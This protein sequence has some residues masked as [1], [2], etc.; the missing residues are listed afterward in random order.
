M[1]MFFIGVNGLIFQ[2]NL[3]SIIIVIFTKMSIGSFHCTLVHA[4]LQQGEVM[5]NRRQR[6]CI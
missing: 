1:F 6:R 5:E 2:Q 4:C 3:F